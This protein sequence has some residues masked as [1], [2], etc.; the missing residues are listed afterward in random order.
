MHRSTLLLALTF[1]AACG[2]E[3][4]EPVV[5]S[6][7]YALSA[8]YD[9]SLRVP[10]CSSV[11]SVCDS[12]TLLAGRGSMGPELNAPN[13]LQSSCADGTGGTYRS[14]ESLEK[15]TV[16]TLDGSPM[17]PGKQVRL[18]AVVWAY[19]AYTSDKLDLYYAA[20]ASSPTWTFLTTL[21]PTGPGS[22][23]L[24]V[25]YTLPAGPLQAVRGRFRYGGAAAPCG[26][27][28]YTDHDDLAFPVGTA[29]PDTQPPTVSLTSP[30]PGASVAQV[31]AMSA[32]ASDDRGVVRVDFFGDGVLV[33]SDAAAPFSFS[34]STSA[35]A[36]TLQAKAYDAAGNEGSSTSVSVQA[37]PAPSVTILQPVANAIVAAPL[38][39]VASASGESAI[40]QVQFLVGTT[41]W[42]T[43]TTAPYEA[44][45]TNLGGTIP[46][47]VRAFDVLGNTAD[48]TLTVRVDG[49]KP[50]VAVLTPAHASLISGTR[51]VTAN[52]IDDVQVQRV[53]FFANDVLIGTDTSEPWG[54]SWDTRG[55]PN[56]TVSVRARAYDTFERFADST[57]LVTVFNDEIPPTVQ[58][59]APTAGQVLSGSFTL[60]A[61]A[62]D[63]S[64]V[65]SV[66]FYVDA[67]LVGTDSS[68][69]YSLVY[70]TKAVG[71]G[72]HTVTAR[73]TDS[74]GNSAA[75]DVQ[76]TVD[77]DVTPPSV[78]LS[79]PTAG[80]VLEGNVN[81]A[82]LAS[83]DRGV[84]R[85]EFRVNGVLMMVDSA[86]PYAF[87]WYTA[88]ESNGTKSLTARAY[89]AAGNATTSA[90]VSVTLNN[91]KT[92]PVVSI[93]SPAPNSW[94][95]G[96]VQVS[97][98]ATDD[99]G[100]VRVELYADDVK[101][102]TQYAPPYGFTWET[103]GLSAGSHMLYA[104]AY[105]AAGNSG[106]VT[107]YVT[108]VIP[109]APPEV[110]LLT[111][112]EGESV[113]GLVTLSANA[114]D[115]VSVLRVEFLVDG[116]IVGGA[117]SNPWS[118]PWD[119]TTVANG[120][121][122]VSARAWDGSGNS[123]TSAAVSITVD[124][125][126]PPPPPPT[127]KEASYDASLGVPA[128]AEQGDSCSSGQLLVG[129]G[130]LGPELNAPNTLAGACQD[131]TY[132][133][134]YS[135]ESIE[136]VKVQTQEGPLLSAGKL[137]LVTVDVY[138][139]G[140]SDVL[141]LYHAP[142]ASNPTW[143]LVSSTPAPGNGHLSFTSTLTLPEGPRQALRASFRYKGVESPCTSGGYDD[144]DDLVFTVAP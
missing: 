133:S 14:D 41:V 83:D 98:T 144:H 5:A 113:S 135:D 64:S 38:R 32:S 110:S 18:E 6:Q 2:G 119:S 29:A 134:L 85:I 67:V 131:G 8:L 56:G 20:N 143:T 13:T 9:S 132:G 33:G 57:V 59:T 128:C 36:H 3:E 31:I 40:S 61:T 114:T 21:T 22:Q 138:S 71:N 81:V 141:D 52:A 120:V 27:I 45:L 49:S 54:V 111:P 124:N 66:E 105:D 28:A 23:V 84:T 126:A 78:A 50:Q 19:A 104:V 94:V 74:K 65:S 117:T 37:R 130:P 39:V 73:A 140:S 108:V 35:G 10:R 91:D 51:E 79:A 76:V 17:A 68:A 12:G 96:T 118:F 25:T 89:D 7:T 15:L 107:Q 123:T 77:N 97:A 142:D 136:R 92:H 129:R 122:S 82:A 70:N 127:L 69:P 115:D 100:V 60:Q 112:L 30:A 48:A 125:G 53:E 26:A 46:L 42:V 99:R 93:P 47:T 116:A 4:P 86:A 72:P 58:L 16:R 1:L 95:T 34:W 137:A 88:Q 101:M 103:A 106:G 102:A 121:Y 87:T 109:N 63:N 11:S 75:H 24:S 80:A 44:E 90:A 139:F 43:D 62:T 55:T